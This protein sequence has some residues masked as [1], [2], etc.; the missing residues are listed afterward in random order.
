MFKRVFYFGAGIA[1]GA[2]GTV[3][4]QRKVRAQLERAKPSHLVVVATDATKRVGTTVRD[5]VVEG[6]AAA[7]A[8][9]DE[10]RGRFDPSPQSPPPS[11]SPPTQ[12]RSVGRQL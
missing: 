1:A 12:L 10:L 6:R 3:Y 4:A 2:T 9:E 7:R 11:A 5:A 8:R